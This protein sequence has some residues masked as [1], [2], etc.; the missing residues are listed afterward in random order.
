LEQHAADGIGHAGKVVA[1]DGQELF[2]GDTTEE[3][4]HKQMRLIRKDGRAFH[5]DYSQD[6]GHAFMRTKRIVGLC[7]DGIVRR[8]CG[9]R[10]ETMMARGCKHSF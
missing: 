2:V 3:V 8:W 9:A 1:I 10:F 6:L 4:S 7:D 5:A